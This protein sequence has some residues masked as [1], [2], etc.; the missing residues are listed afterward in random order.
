MERNKKIEYKIA[1]T[2]AEDI[3]KVIENDKGGLVKTIIHEKEEREIKKRNMSPESKKNKLFMLLSLFFILLAL[4]IL[5][6]FFFNE[7][8]S[9]IQTETRFV[10]IIFN[11]KSTFIEVE[12]FNKDE[13]T[14]TILNKIKTIEIKPGEVEG[15]Y[16]TEN[17]QI[18]GLRRFISIFKSN[19]VPGDNPLFVNDNFLLGVVNSGTDPLLSSGQFFMLI[20]ARST[21]DIFES[22]RVWES[23]MFLD[24]HKF[25]GLT[26]SSETK[27]LLTKEFEDSMVENKNARILYDTSNK[28]VLMY[29]FADDPSV[30]ITNTENA[31]HE[32]MLRLASSQIKK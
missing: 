9:T 10:P 19:F 13:I 6:F 14:Q 5:F 24:L 25:F 23:K 28:I 30:I 4:A 27:Y 22:L 17:K 11:D 29:I 3:A 7:N 15:I 26:I 20:K 16:L 32:I 31:A 1:Q 2:Y 8:I 18:I 21:A 12:G